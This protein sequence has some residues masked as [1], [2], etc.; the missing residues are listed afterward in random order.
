MQA[1]K[2]GRPRKPE[3]ERINL[4]IDKDI[5][6]KLR[7]FAKENEKNLSDVAEESLRQ[8]FELPKTFEDR[9]TIKMGNGEYSKFPFIP[10][11][12]EEK[13]IIHETGLNLVAVDKN[14]IIA[15]INIAPKNFTGDKWI[16][17]IQATEKLN[18]F[19]ALHKSKLL[20]FG[21]ITEQFYFIDFLQ[22][23]T[24]NMEKINSK[25]TEEIIIRYN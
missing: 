25:I 3:K 16:F 11:A 21:Y 1:K 19:S 24:K 23:N 22:F 7:S 2:I 5:L 10:L 14:K 20:Y 12:N 15:A 6:E 13:E 9:Q 17:G 18:N 8:Y 4:T